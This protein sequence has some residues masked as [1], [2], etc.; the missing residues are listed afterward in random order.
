MCAWPPGPPVNRLGW[1]SPRESHLKASPRANAFSKDGPTASGRASPLT[2]R[3]DVGPASWIEIEVHRSEAWRI[4]PRPID[5]EAQGA[6][7]NREQPAFDAVESVVGRPII[8]FAA[9]KPGTAGVGGEAMPKA[10]TPWLGP[11]GHGIRP[12]QCRKKHRSCVQP[13]NIPIGLRAG[14]W[15]AAL[16]SD[17]TVIGSRLRPGRPL[18]KPGRLSGGT[19]VCG[20]WPMF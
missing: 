13:V 18:R 4:H 16:S 5:G 15:L 6:P 8:F 11:S 17:G 1:P 9:G 20:A 14:R 2:E 7:T 10:M 19:R 3:R 12:C